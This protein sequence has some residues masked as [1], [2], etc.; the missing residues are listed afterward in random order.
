MK[1]LQHLIEYAAL[2][3]F[4]FCA[5]LLPLSWARFLM[6]R[7]AD[8]IFYVVPVRKKVVIKNLTDSF[9]DEKSP[10]EILGIARRAY[11]QFAQTMLELLFFPK[12]SPEDIDK[13]VTV[14]GLD[15]LA[16]VKKKG[17]GAILVGAHFGNWEL[18]GAALA[19]HFPVTFIVGLQSNRLADGLLNSYRTAKGIKIVSLKVALRG[20]LQVLKDNE[21]VALLSDQDAHEK[22]TFVN[23]FGRPAS[24]PK[25]PALFALRT[26]APLVMCSMIRENGHFRA[27]FEEVPRP[28]PSGNEEKDVHDYTQAYTSMLEKYTRQH[29]DHWFWMH[30]RWKTK[31]AL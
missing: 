24:T 2:A 29:P 22:G 20:V 17:T 5:R 9:K 15:Y 14:E 30:K 23:F 18:M 16:S 13:M 12:L 4:A 1:K 19:R 6:R 27:V 26:G 31:P 10:E 28:A 7:F 11:A 21:F 8:F 25:G 3:V